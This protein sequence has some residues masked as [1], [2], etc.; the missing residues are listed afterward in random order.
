MD[1]GYNNVMHNLAFNNQQAMDRATANLKG[2]IDWYNIHMGSSFGTT[3]ITPQIDDT[4]DPALYPDLTNIADINFDGHLNPNRPVGT[5]DPTNPQEN[6]MEA[7]AKKSLEFGV[8]NVILNLHQFPWWCLGKFDGTTTTPLTATSDIHDARP[9]T[10][11]WTTCLNMV[12]TLV[13]RYALAANN[14][15]TGVNIRYFSV[16]HERKGYL[17]R[18]DGGAGWDFGGFAGTPDDINGPYADMGFAHYFMGIYDAIKEVEAELRLSTG[19]N[20]ITLYVCGPYVPFTLYTTGSLS[21]TEVLQ[22][23][24]H[25]MHASRLPVPAGHSVTFGEFRDAEWAAIREFYGVTNPLGKNPHVFTFDTRIDLKHKVGTTTYPTWPWADGWTDLEVAQH[26]WK[27]QMDGIRY[28]FTDPV[29]GM[30]IPLPDIIISKETYFTHEDEPRDSTYRTALST[31][32]MAEFAREGIACPMLWSET[33]EA[34]GDEP[35]A[36]LITYPHATLDQGGDPQPLLAVTRAFH[37]HFGPTQ[38]LYSITVANPNVYA[39]ASDTCV[40]L[41]NKTDAE[42]K[43]RLGLTGVRYNLT[44]YQTRIIDLAFAS[45]NFERADSALAPGGDWV[46]EQGTAGDVAFGISKGRLYCVTDDST[47]N[48]ARAYLPVT[49]PLGAILYRWVFTTPSAASGWTG[50]GVYFGGGIRHTAPGTG[51]FWSNGFDN[52]HLKLEIWDGGLNPVR[53]IR[54]KGTTGVTLWEPGTT[55]EVKLLANRN[56]YQVWLNG[57]DQW[58]TYTDPDAEG[59]AITSGNDVGVA[60]YGQDTRKSDVFFHKV[61]AYRR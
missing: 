40:V 38:P 60:I 50:T 11:Y 51:V 28:V 52:T 53:T 10:K 44:P 37:D 42:Q 20:T 17:K 16:G 35:A 5:F 49:L 34:Q 55:Y 8:S 13:R 3:S 24:N 4:D 21:S 18:K 29:N 58:G 32:G 47:D 25:P 23:A 48:R 39:F 6:S 54:Q 41:V 12:K 27:L 22:D 30:G 61:G 45:D 56:D 46:V 14:P 1:T 31:I 36:G 26:I 9:L 57:E 33:G 2:S 19:D 7:W 59:N 15:E 43:V